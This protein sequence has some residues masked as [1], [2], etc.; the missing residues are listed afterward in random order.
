MSLKAH[1]VVVHETKDPEL[2]IAE[3][4]YDGLVTTTGGRSAAYLTR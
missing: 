4:D 3:Y 2:V 1:H